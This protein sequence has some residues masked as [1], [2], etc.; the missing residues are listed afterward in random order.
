MMVE[1]LRGNN[2][3]SY[4]NCNENAK[5]PNS[6]ANNAIIHF[7]KLNCNYPDLPFIQILS[8]SFRFFSLNLVKF[9]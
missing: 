9:R 4:F 2:F 6:L 1:S 5:L 3:T 8:E 7:L